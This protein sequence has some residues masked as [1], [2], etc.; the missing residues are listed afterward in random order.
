[1]IISIKYEDFVK[2]YSKRNHGAVYYPEVMKKFKQNSDIRKISDTFKI[3]YS[4]VWNW[5][6]NKSIPVSFIAYKSIKKEFNEEDIKNLAPIIGYI[7]G[8]GGILP[9]GRIHYCN[10]EKFLINDFINHFINVFNEKPI[11]RR[12]PDIFRIKCSALVGKSLWC[13]FGKFSYGKDTKIIT[14]KIQSMP[15]EWKAKMLQT[16][17]NDDGS[18]PAYKL[19]AIKQK[20]KPLV[21]FI[22]DTLLEWGIESHISEDD[23]KWHLRICGYRNLMKFKTN[24][25]F[26]EGYR[27][28]ERLTKTIENI[29]NP[30]FITKQKILDI[31]YESPKTSKEILKELDLKLGTI[32]GHLLGWKRKK[33]KRKS[34]IGLVGNGLVKMEKRGRINVYSLEGNKSI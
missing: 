28:S 19:V 21:V 34:Q 3:P 25:D 30:H 16:W 5:V 9:N 7:F 24:V 23:N 8:D 14:P 32:N 20:L 27:K 31:L 13:L 12:E 33:S 2:T 11:L 15:L 17:F 18:V 10:T 29:K 4:L 26:S 22:H 1:M 6:R